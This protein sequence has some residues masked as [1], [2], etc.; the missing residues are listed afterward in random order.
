MTGNEMMNFLA[1]TPEPQKPLDALDP[2]FRKQAIQNCMDVLREHSRADEREEALNLLRL[3]GA[4][5][6]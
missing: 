4:L 1:I 5:H 2:E 3:L 6:G